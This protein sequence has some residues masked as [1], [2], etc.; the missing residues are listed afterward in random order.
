MNR[1]EFKTLIKSKGIRQWEVVGYLGISEDTFSRKLRHDLEPD[2]E[3]RVLRAIEILES[4]DEIPVYNTDVREMAKLHNV[5]Q[6]QIAEYIGMSEVKLAEK[7]R[8]NLDQDLRRQII[9]A[10]RVLGSPAGSAKVNAAGLPL[11]INK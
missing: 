2:L 11:I 10:I 6:W 5:K 1:S 8:Y 4:R 9:E 3:K 7:M